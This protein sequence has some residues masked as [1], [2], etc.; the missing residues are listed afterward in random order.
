M[1]GDTERDRKTEKLG[2][3]KV[4]GKY[5]GVPGGVEKWTGNLECIDQDILFTSIKL[6][7][8]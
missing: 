8:K 7:N 3:E 6:K 1:G 5:I 4:G 2:R